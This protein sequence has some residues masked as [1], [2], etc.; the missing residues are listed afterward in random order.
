MKP[1]FNY[2][3]QKENTPQIY[4]NSHSPDLL[5]VTAAVVNTKLTKTPFSF[6]KFSFIVMSVGQEVGDWWGK[7]FCYGLTKA[8]KIS[9]LYFEHCLST[10]LGVNFTQQC[11]AIQQNQIPTSDKPKPSLQ[12]IISG[13]DTTVLWP[14]WN[15]AGNRGTTGWKMQQWGQIRVKKKW[16][17][18]VDLSDTSQRTNSRASA[19]PL[20]VPPVL[21]RKQEVLASPVIGMF[22]QHPVALHDIDRRDVTCVETLMQ[23]WAVFH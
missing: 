2:H 14:H 20:A 1:K 12:C 3:I 7:L 22:M 11:K 4:D 5:I 16:W 21:S 15:S 17:E 19:S 23:V 8:K 9:T 6:I 10:E 13:L 18:S